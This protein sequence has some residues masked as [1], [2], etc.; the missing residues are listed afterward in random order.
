MT[1]RCIAAAKDK[2]VEP[3]VLATFPLPDPAAAPARFSFSGTLPAMAGDEDICFQ[4]TA[5]LAGPYYAVE[6]AVLKEA[7]K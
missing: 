3:I 2:T 1:V 7:A 6:R 5:P 4:F